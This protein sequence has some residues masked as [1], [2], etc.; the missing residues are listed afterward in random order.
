MTTTTSAPGVELT[1]PLA[2]LKE[3]FGDA[4]QPAAFEGA[5]IDPA[6][7]LEVAQHIRD[8]LGYD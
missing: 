7:L 4:V 2:A 8:G 3:K 6:Y 1:G 5:L